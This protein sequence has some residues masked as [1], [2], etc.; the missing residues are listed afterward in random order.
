MNFMLLRKTFKKL[1]SQFHYQT[2]II[3]HYN[4]INAQHIKKIMKYERKLQSSVSVSSKKKFDHQGNLNSHFITGWLYKLFFLHYTL[5][6][7]L[8]SISLKF[9]TDLKFHLVPNLCIFDDFLH[10]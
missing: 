10:L 7:S 8:K 3:K 5:L 2:L 1:I 9:Y 6:F 4:F